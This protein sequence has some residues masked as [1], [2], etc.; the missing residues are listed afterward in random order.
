MSLPFRTD[1][2]GRA[3]AAGLAAQG[4]LS[5]L[6][7]LTLFLGAACA[8]EN[9]TPEQAI[10]GSVCISCHNPDPSL[11]GPVGPPIKGSSLELVQAKTL[12]GEYH[13]GYVPKRPTR[14]MNKIPLT[15]ADVLALAAFLR[16]P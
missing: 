12:R 9:L 4:A 13:P 16:A 7:G 10:Y 1:K 5:A 15:D 2:A 3:K 11:V 8:E 14:I 6:V